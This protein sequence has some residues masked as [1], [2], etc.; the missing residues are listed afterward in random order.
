MLFAIEFKDLVLQMW[1]NLFVLEIA[2]LF[3]STTNADTR[4]KVEYF[5]A[6]S[7]INKNCCNKL[8][9]TIRITET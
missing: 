9:K 8:L 1:I 4:K 3:L 2:A 6:K 5:L 7:E